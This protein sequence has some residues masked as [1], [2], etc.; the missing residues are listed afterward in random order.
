MLVFLQHD[1]AGALAHDEAVA[2]LVPG[3]AGGLGGILALGRQRLAGVKASD[4]N[5]ADGAFGAARDHHVGI[6][7]HDQPRRIADGMGAG[8]AGGDDR[9][10][11]PLEAEADRDLPGH[12]VDQRTGNEE[13]RDPLRPALLD[14][15][16]GFRDRVQPANPRADHHAGADAVLLVGR[17][18]A[19]IRHRLRGG[20][21]A[22]KNEIIDLAAILGLHP[23][24]GIEG[25]VAAVAKRDLT[26]IFRHHILGVETGD[27]PGPGFPGQKPRPGLID[28]RGQRRDHSQ[29][30]DDNS[31]HPQ[32]PS[33]RI[34]AR[35]LH[36]P[37]PA[38]NAMRPD[39]PWSGLARPTGRK[40][41]ATPQLS[42]NGNFREGLSLHPLGI[43]LFCGRS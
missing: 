11:R 19:G 30:S 24:I 5:L 26:G 10:V 42:R 12:K 15:H 43:G 34:I 29:T 8:R 14:Q 4:A 18:P 39:R 36:A 21:H 31:A 20:G 13:G 22:V 1:D 9:M 7:Q 16:R 32:A 23:V 41:T 28:P 25:P 3:P 40:A 37:R 38:R 27:R 17:N 33:Q 35:F 6:A 2:V